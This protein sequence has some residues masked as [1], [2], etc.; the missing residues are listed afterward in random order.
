DAPR[1]RQA[2]AARLPLPSWAADTARILW[3][4][5]VLVKEAPR[6]RPLPVR[7]A[8]PDT[9]P[10]PRVAEVAPDSARPPMMLPRGGALARK[11]AAATQAAGA[12]AAV[13][14]GIPGLLRSTVGFVVPMPGTEMI[15]VG[16]VQEGATLQAAN[17]MPS[18]EGQNIE[19]VGQ[20]NQ[21]TLRIRIR[22]P[23]DN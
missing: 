2:P 7:I 5:R 8:P 19:G 18:L 23:A 22:R 1:Y 3:A 16:V 6:P 11:E 10:R 17:R 9:A 12:S 20:V 21:A 15:R 14:A 13:R 4:P